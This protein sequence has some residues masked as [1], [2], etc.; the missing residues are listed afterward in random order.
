LQAGIRTSFLEIPST[1][2][3]DAFLLPNPK[4]GQAIAGFVA[5]VLRSERQCTGGRS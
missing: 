1:Y 5:S 2:G 3:H 4:L